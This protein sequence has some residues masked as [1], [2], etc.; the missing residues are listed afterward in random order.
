MLRKGRI[1]SIIRDERRS[2][3]MTTGVKRENQ[4][5]YDN[6]RR[7]VGGNGTYLHDFETEPMVKLTLTLYE[8]DTMD[9][10]RVVIDI[11]D[12]IMEKHPDWKRISEPRLKE[13]VTSN[14]GKK[15]TVNQAENGT[16]SFLDGELEL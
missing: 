5:A 11:R 8:T 12:S 9:R 6:S 4:S 2:C 13:I 10:E 3:A 16:I 14:R 15:V 1:T 7:Y